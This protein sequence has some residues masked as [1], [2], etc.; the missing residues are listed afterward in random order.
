MKK[1]L[2]VIHDMKLGGAQKSLLSFLTGLE[3]SQY[4]REY[5]IDLL[6]TQPV[7]ELLS[8][9]PQQV[10]RI[11]P[12]RELLWL[13]SHFNKKLLQNFS[14][15]GLRG[16]L[17][18]ILGK[19]L[20]RFP[21]NLSSAQ[22]MWECWKNLIPALEDTYDVAISYIDG[23]PNYYVMDK[24]RAAKKVLWY[25]SQYQKQGYCPEFD[26]AY[27]ENCDRVVTVS[28]QC[29]DCIVQAFPHLEQKI[30]VLENITLRQ[31]VLSRSLEA[32]GEEFDICQ[33][34]R[35]LTVGRLHPMK[36]ID[37]AIEAAKC[38]KEKDIPFLW[39]V[40]GEGSERPK[41]EK[42]IEKYALQEQVLLVGARENPYPYM[43]KCDLLVQPS[44]VEG[45]SIVLDEAKILCKPIVATNYA[46][47]AASVTHEQTGLVVDMT[48]EGI[49]D[50]ICR[51]LQDHTLTDNITKTLAANP[52]SNEEELTRY[53]QVMF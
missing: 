3:D 22:K 50:G 33:A 35:L 20:G 41:L 51:L 21:K 23:Y 39:V 38:L 15:K 9:I 25:H 36:G 16:E 49:A 26:G 43:A 6:V 14:F 5:E 4:G 18:W 32:G 27:L 34:A 31:Q 7:G 42:M 52:E 30:Q 48:P 53:V 45:K 28:H 2:I 47:V 40:V 12:S 44:R 11:A 19:R 17:R 37:L 46:T 13:S 1:I 29:R 10:K 24:V 8:H